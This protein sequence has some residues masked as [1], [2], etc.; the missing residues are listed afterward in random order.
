MKLNR[1]TGHKISKRTITVWRDC[2]EEVLSEWHKGLR[3]VKRMLRV[4]Y[5][6]QMKMQKMSELAFI[7]AEGLAMRTLTHPEGEFEQKGFCKA[8]ATH[9]E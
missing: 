4:K 5:K 3:K 2:D 9:F 1:H 7:Q 6:E 8:C